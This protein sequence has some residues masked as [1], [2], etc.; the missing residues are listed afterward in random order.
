MNELIKICFTGNR[1]GL[2]S[3]QKNQIISILD[4]YNKKF[5]NIDRMSY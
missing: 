5:I 1:Y 2:N 4:K 3:G